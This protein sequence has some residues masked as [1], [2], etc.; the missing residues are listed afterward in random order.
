M[1]RKAWEVSCA[2]L[3]SMFPPS[4]VW[5]RTLQTGQCRDDSARPARA[6]SQ[7]Q[8]EQRKMWQS[9]LLLSSLYECNNAEIVFA[10]RNP[11]TLEEGEA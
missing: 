7:A 9:T 4:A 5:D 2:Q 3:L 10:E 6:W 11:V 1:L 8:P